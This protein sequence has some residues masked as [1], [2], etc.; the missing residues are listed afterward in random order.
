MSA[1]KGEFPEQMWPF[2]RLHTLS[3]AVVGCLV[4]A[5]FTQ[6]GFWMWAGMFG[7]L[8]GCLWCAA[9]LYRDRG[10]PRRA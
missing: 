1:K 9:L 2:G 4:L 6:N 5:V 7:A 8:G 10:R 3:L